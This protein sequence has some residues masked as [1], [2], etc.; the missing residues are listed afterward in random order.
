MALPN[1]N[2]PCPERQAILGG[3]LR[4]SAL[5]YHSPACG[6][7]LRWPTRRAQQKMPPIHTN[8][9]GKPPRPAI[10]WFRFKSDLEE[11][12]WFRPHATLPCQ[13]ATAVRWGAPKG[14]RFVRNGQDKQRSRWAMASDSSGAALPPSAD[15][16]PIIGSGHCSCNALRQGDDDTTKAPPKA[17]PGLCPMFR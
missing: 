13:L 4:A 1:A 5:L 7:S 11:D 2:T 14:V 16:R 17:G 3:R 15:L 10:P 9:I 8:R 6:L 12:L